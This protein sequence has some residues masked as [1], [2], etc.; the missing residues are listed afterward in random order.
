VVATLRS[1]AGLTVALRPGAAL[2]LL[3]ML[4]L[5]VDV[6]TA[7]GQTCPP[8]VLN[9]ES[10]SADITLDYGSPATC[11]L[12]PTTTN[13]GYV[14]NSKTYKLQIVASLGG[15][16]QIY[17]Q[18]QACTPAYV[19]YRTIGYT[20]FAD[21][22]QSLGCC[23]WITTNQLYSYDSH[24]GSPTTSGPYSWVPTVLGADVITSQTHAT[25]TSCN[26]AQPFAQN[27]A[28]TVN[29]LSCQPIFNDQNGPTVHLTPSQI[30][31]YSD[32]SGLSSYLANAV[33]TWN[34]ALSGT[35]VSFNVVTASCGSGAA[36]ITVTTGS[37]SSCGYSSWTANGTTGEITSN[38]VLTINQNWS[39]VPFSTEGLERTFA[40]ELGHFLGL[41]N[42]STTACGIPDAAMQP[43]FDCAATTV[44]HAPTTNDIVPVSS[45]VY[46][47]NTK[48]T[49]GF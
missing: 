1:A 46:G 16:C 3:V 39:T 43:N 9:P 4:T 11:T 23:A 20:Q 26:F 22:A 37:L 19:S 2:A 47:G 18:N 6:G 8:T 41:G 29:V 5:F 17:V 14:K 10:H 34:T 48:T 13:G 49:C 35:G 12:D 45:T 33:G 42:Y 30:D 28:L 27:H 36:C 40:H 25:T 38:A 31:V 44:M 32:T 24:N 7:E 15:S 21:S